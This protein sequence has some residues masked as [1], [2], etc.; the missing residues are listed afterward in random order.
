MFKELDIV[1]L[2]RDIPEHKLKAGD[3][4]AVVHVYANAK[5]YEVEFINVRGETVALLT[6][7][8][9]DL[10]PMADEEILHVR[11]LERVAA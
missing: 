6:L 4:G 1:V 8:D 5:G 2:K 11:G 3:V 9:A 10:R 7:K